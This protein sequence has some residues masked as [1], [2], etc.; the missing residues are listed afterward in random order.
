MFPRRHEH[1]KS[2]DAVRLRDA[3][4]ERNS[5]VRFGHGHFE[6]THSRSRYFVGFEELE[7]FVGRR[8]RRTFER[9]HQ[10]VRRDH[11]VVELHEH[12]AKT[13]TDTRI[14]PQIK[15]VRVCQ[16]SLGHMQCEPLALRLFSRLQFIRLEVGIFV[17]NRP[18]DFHAHF[19]HDSSDSLSVV[20]KLLFRTGVLHE[21]NG[22]IQFA[23]VFQHQGRHLFCYLFLHIILPY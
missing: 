1:R 11:R 2:R 23:R 7:T 4:V 13:P 12:D 5:R 20:Q 22:L 10:Q 15:G 9:V 18:H 19:A 17:E 6:S 16:G 14:S 21:L 8:I 3:T